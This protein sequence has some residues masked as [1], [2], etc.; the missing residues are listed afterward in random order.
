MLVLSTNIVAFACCSPKSM[1]PTNIKPLNVVVLSLCPLSILRRDYQAQTFEEHY[2][3]YTGAGQV[4]C[5]N[6]IFF[7]LQILKRKVE[8]QW[9]A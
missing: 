4:P 5:E 3:C 8:H 2:F 1:S 7:A 9:K 6:Y